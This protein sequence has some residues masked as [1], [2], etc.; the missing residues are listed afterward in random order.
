MTELVGSNV[1]VT[2]N[3]FNP[4]ILTQL[5]LVKHGVLLEEDL[6]AGFVFS[7]GVSQIQAKEFQMLIVPQ[8]LQFVPK[9]GENEGA[10]VEGKIGAI[11]NAL[12]HTP[13]TG[14]GL[15]ITW[16]FTPGQEKITQLTRRLFCT[17]NAAPFSFFS[18]P[19]ARFG[20]YLSKDFDVFRLKL[21][22]KPILTKATDE[23]ATD[24]LQFAFNFHK[25][26]AADTAID[27]CRK[28]L[29]LWDMAKREAERI[30]VDT[31][32]LEAI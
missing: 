28:V 29:S 31:A 13:Y 17:N 19:D 16:H 14:I 23:P 5:W 24:R 2:A 25:D 27:D 1:V 3:Q 12:P 4:S 10:L 21:D 26:L 15:N 22:I 32:K 30:V 20:S 18:D 8:M 7:E 6:E 9:P 11:I